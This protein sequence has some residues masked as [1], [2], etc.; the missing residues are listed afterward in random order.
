[1]HILPKGAQRGC[2]YSLYLQ[3]LLEELRPLEGLSLLAQRR[4]TIKLSS[5]QKERRQ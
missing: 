1:M 4:I 3:Y 5:L 2:D